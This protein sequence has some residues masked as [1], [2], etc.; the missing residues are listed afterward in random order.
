MKPAINSTT[1]R[2]SRLVLRSRLV[3]INPFFYLR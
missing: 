1:G 3:I 2:S